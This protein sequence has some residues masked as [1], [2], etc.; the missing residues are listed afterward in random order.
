MTR[1]GSLMLAGA[2]ALAG[3]SKDKDRP[4]QEAPTSQATI[5]HGDKLG[6][7]EGGG[8]KA[9][10]GRK[11]GTRGSAQPAGPDPKVIER[12]AYV[13]ALGGCVLCH[14]PI[15]PQGPDMAR[16]F[17]GGMT[18]KEA[19]GTWTAPNI[20]PDPE[21]GIGAW[22]DEQIGAAIRDGVRPDGSK[23]H[24]VMPWPFFH[25]MTDDDTRA[26]IA[27][28][29]VQK[30]V[31]HQVARSE[32]PSMEIPLPPPS[33]VDPVD[34]PVGHGAY[35]AGI[36]HCVMCHTPMTEKGPDFSK[37]FAGGFHMELPPELATGHFVSSNITPDEATGI[38]SW[39]EA[40]IVKALRTMTRPD[41]T[42][43]EGPMMM[44]AP[45]WSQL[46]D[47]DATAIA[48]FLKS[49]PPV[50]HKVPRSTGKLK[51]PGPPAPT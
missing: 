49:L 3:C 28:L 7:G 30:P 38:G 22:S 8:E 29:R 15:G 24:P 46:T 13:A 14:T 45:L 25:G 11:D 5:V 16:P 23:L 17:A 27:F 32:L 37:A 33:R 35:L 4:G 1:I 51:R 9:A 12:G 48:R 36:M 40:D 41:G 31:V 2:L 20:T 50:K 44:Y 18:V 34:D 6:K 42:S 43:I 26:L 39:S 47:D 21:T 19:F 10:A